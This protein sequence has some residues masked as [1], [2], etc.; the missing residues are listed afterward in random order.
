M[1][2][3]DV[4]VTL[5]DDFDVAKA[6]NTHNSGGLN[7][8]ARPTLITIAWARNW[9][10]RWL[11]QPWMGNYDLLLTSSTLAQNFYDEF[12]RRYG[13]P[14]KC[15]H[16]CPAETAPTLSCTTLGEVTNEPNT[17]T[18]D[19]GNNFKNFVNVA[20]GNAVSVFKSIF[21]VSAKRVPLSCTILEQKKNNFGDNVSRLI[22]FQYLQDDMD[23]DG[24]LSTNPPIHNNSPLKQQSR[25][26]SQY[27]VQVPVKVLRIGTNI[28]RFTKKGW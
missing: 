6:L 21:S 7:D 5:L 12:G 14:V 3:I 25:T 16:S 4:L 11:Q 22:R 10:H 2:E 23:T 9:F 28:E 27:R 8:G 15:I 18:E 26:I 19:Y 1:R 20:N 17:N 24:H 13:Y